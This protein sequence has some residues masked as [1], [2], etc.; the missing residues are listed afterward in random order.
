MIQMREDVSVSLASVL[1]SLFICEQLA[2]AQLAQLALMMPVSLTEELSS[3]L[4]NSV[5][6]MKQLMDATDYDRDFY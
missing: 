4:E 6:E 1:C 5:S 3:Y 2:L